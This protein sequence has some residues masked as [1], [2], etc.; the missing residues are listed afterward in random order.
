ML[1]FG[2]DSL[3]RDLEVITAPSGEEALLEISRQPVDLL[4]AD[5]R[6][7]GMTGLDLFAKA[8]ML[9]PQAKVILITGFTDPLTQHQVAAA[10]ADAFFFKPVQLADFLNAV[11]ECLGPLPPAAPAQN[12]ADRLTG[13]RQELKAI[14]VALIDDRGR[15]LAIAG[16]LPDP[17]IE[18][19]LIHMLMQLCSTGMAIS[20]FL[21]LK[22]PQDL[23]CFAGATHDLSLA[24]VGSTYALLV[25]TH[26]QPGFPWAAGAAIRIAAQDILTNLEDL[27]VPLRLDEEIISPSGEA[28]IDPDEVELALD[29]VDL[30]QPQTQAQLQS[31]DVDAFWD[32][33]VTEQDSPGIM[34]AGALSY[35]QAR[36]LGLAPVDNEL[37]DSL[38]HIH[39]GTKSVIIFRACVT[40]LAT[41]PCATLHDGVRY[42]KLGH[43]Y[44]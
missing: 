21:G 3:G 14:S 16:D 17:D 41:P 5:V 23:F 11:A 15:L 12:L 39:L 2:L 22:S 10:G 29:L 28:V 31:K 20:F 38:E 18:T 25:F 37:K 19:D 1:R 30:L 34:S 33:L 7:A 27:G 4:I 42:G 36:R 6:L 43:I 26:K 24:H 35:E 44:R 32:S 9:Y 13:L 40:A 8:R